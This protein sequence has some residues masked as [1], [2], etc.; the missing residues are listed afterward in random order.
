MRN[1]TNEM[2]CCIT[3]NSY[4]KLRN[5]VIL[6]NVSQIRIIHVAKPVGS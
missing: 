5:G 2:M 6:L 4:D 1:P 3:K